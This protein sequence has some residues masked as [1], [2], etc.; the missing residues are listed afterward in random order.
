MEKSIRT[1]LTR[2]GVSTTVGDVSSNLIWQPHWK[3]VYWAG[4]FYW[5]AL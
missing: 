5:K 4:F 3:P 2:V 1:W